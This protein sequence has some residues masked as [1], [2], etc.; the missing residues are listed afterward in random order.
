MKGP[1]DPEVAHCFDDVGS[2]HTDDKTFDYNLGLDFPALIRK[3]A[4]AEELNTWE[5]CNMG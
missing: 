5:N 4:V 3:T 2:N 1:V